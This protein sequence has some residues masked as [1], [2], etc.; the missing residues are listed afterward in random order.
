MERFG[1]PAE[2]TWP[3]RRPRPSVRGGVLVISLASVTPRCGVRLPGGP[4]LVRVVLGRQPD[5][6]RARGG[7][8]EGGLLRGR[9]RGQLLLELLALGQQ[10]LLLLAPQLLTVLLLLLAEARGEHFLHARV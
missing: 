4:S 3:G 2:D 9:G 1:A 8:Q 10:S 5:A 7:A 6:G